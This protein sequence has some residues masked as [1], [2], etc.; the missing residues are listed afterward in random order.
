MASILV[1]LFLLGSIAFAVAMVVTIMHNRTRERD[2]N[3]REVAREF[4]LQF[5]AGSWNS[6]PAIAGTFNGFFISVDTQGT[7]ED[8][9]TRYTVR[10]PGSGGEGVGLTKQSPIHFSFVKLLTGKNDIEIGDREFDA[11]VLIDARDPV[12]AARYLSPM[13]RQAVM[14]VL[15]HQPFRSPRITDTSIVVD[16]LGIESEAT[17]LRDTVSVLLEAART[18]S[19]PTDVDLAVG[20]AETIEA[21]SPPQDKVVQEPATPEDRVAPEPHPEPHPEPQLSPATDTPPQAVPRPARP[22]LDQHSVITDLFESGRMGFETDEHFAATYA[23]T[24]VRWSG[25]VDTVRELRN[26]SDFDGTGIKAT[27]LVGSQDGSEMRSRIA[28][29]VVQLPEGTEIER[30]Q[31]VEFTGTLVR[32]DRFTRQLYVADGELQP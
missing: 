5:F 12:A 8:R 1:V 22:T 28:K 17:N 2:E 11:K 30:G 26:D 18:M 32:S 19:A 31:H 16:T 15:Y 27:L 7:N 3:W 14:R 13:R 10:Y 29:A 24:Q 9:V 21:P 4:N 6:G 25:E 23:G 20:A